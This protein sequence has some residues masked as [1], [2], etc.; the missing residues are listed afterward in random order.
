MCPQVE[1]QIDQMVKFIKQEADE[2]ANEIAVSA[3]EVRGHCSH[4]LDNSLRRGM[5][6]LAADQE[7]A[8]TNVGA[9][10]GHWPCVS[11][12]VMNLPDTLLTTSYH[13]VLLHML[14][15]FNIEK[16][17]LLEAEKAK[18]RKDYERREGQ[19]DVKKKM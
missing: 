8:L 17:Q 9:P 19:I 7:L 15:E 13:N 4:L 11:L 12:Q 18:I 6:Y 5:Q 3:E 14:Q 10:S 1:R 2:K 16:L